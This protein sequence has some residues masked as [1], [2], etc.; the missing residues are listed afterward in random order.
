MPDFLNISESE[1]VLSNVIVFVVFLIVDANISYRTN[2]C[3]QL[4]HCDQH[5]I[6]PVKLL[7]FHVTCTV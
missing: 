6:C 4:W 3:S 1:S 2:I 5:V 7:V